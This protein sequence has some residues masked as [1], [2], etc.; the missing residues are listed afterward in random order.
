MNLHTDT[1]KIQNSDVLFLE[2][3]AEHFLNE[4]IIQKC[5]KIYTQKDFFT[6][7]PNKKSEKIIPVDNFE[8]FMFLSF[9]EH[10]NIPEKVIAITGTNGKTSTAW[11]SFNLLTKLHKNACYI[12]T[13]GTY[14][15]KGGQ[16][17]F[18]S[19]LANTT[20]YLADMYHT[21]SFLKEAKNTEYVC[22]EASSHGLDQKRFGNIKFDIGMFLN[23]TQ[24]HL[25]YHKTMEG[26]LYAKLKITQYIKP[27]GVFFIADTINTMNAKLHP[28]TIKT[29]NA[30]NNI[31]DCKISILGTE[32]DFVNKNMLLDYENQNLFHAIL[33]VKFITK[34]N[35]QTILQNAQTLIAPKG[36]LEKVTGSNFIIDFAHTPDA[37]QSVV[38]NLKKSTNQKI[39]AMFGCGGDR[40]ALKRS[41][42][43][44]AA[45]NSDIVIITD[46]NPRTE[47]SATIRSEIMSNYKQEYSQGT[48]TDKSVYKFNVDNK[49]VFEVTDGR[50]SA[51]KFAVENFNSEEFIVLIFGKGHENYQIIGKT[52]L[53]FSDFEMV[54][55][56]LPNSNFE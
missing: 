42:M 41:L 43:L 48:F 25:D 27:E 26:Y 39:V 50:E 44:E 46:D 37:I 47:N 53:P 38:E 21:L 40:D 56:Y 49:V 33:G 1:R 4:D 10:Y 24:D 54:K 5:S 30:Q 29:L 34:I 14:F 32:Y 31:K 6:R 19:E 16:V 2:E 28:N 22:V 20:P 52:K 12:G 3:R 13:I 7:Y 11:L 23:F 45:L 51:I 36:R 55:K 17:Y 18:Y 35:D 15:S 9:Q 8:E